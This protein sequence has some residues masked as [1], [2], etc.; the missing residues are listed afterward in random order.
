MV[1]DGYTPVFV[2]IPVYVRVT[3]CVPTVVLLN[4]LTEQDTIEPPPEAF[5]ILA[6]LLMEPE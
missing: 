3:V 2:T 4:P 1:H 6:I 5:V